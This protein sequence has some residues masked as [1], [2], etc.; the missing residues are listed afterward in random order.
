MAPATS[1]SVR[2]TLGFVRRICLQGVR[3]V[4]KSQVWADH[5]LKIGG[6]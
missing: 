2:C 4:E 3:S 5:G 6:T 1:T